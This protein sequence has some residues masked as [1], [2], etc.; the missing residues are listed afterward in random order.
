MKIQKT[1]TKNTS[2]SITVLDLFDQAVSR[3]AQY[4]RFDKEFR[5]KRLKQKTR[6][7]WDCLE[8]GAR[9]YGSFSKAKTELNK[10]KREGRFGST[11]EIDLAFKY[12]ET[13]C[14]WSQQN[15]KLFERKFIEWGAGDSFLKEALDIPEEHWV[16]LLEQEKLP[17]VRQLRKKRKEVNPKTLVWGEVTSCYIWN[18]VAE[19][20]EIPE[21]KLCELKKMAQEK[22]TA[23]GSSEVLNDHVVE[24]LKELGFKEKQLNKL[25]PRPKSNPDKKEVMTRIQAEKWIA[26]RQAEIEKQCQADYETKLNNIFGAILANTPE[27]IPEDCRQSF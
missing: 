9:K 8:K 11:T 10:L 2:S 13:L 26:K 15:Q 19:K 20:L 4:C 24:V 22:A 18:L 14:M 12:S 27:N 1:T 16:E 6:L 7:L 3:L 21:D 25:L 17:T 5:L 23:A